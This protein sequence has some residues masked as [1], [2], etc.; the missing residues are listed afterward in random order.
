MITYEIT[1]NLLNPQ[2]TQSGLDVSITGAM[3][4]TISAGNINGVAIP[5]TIINI[6]VDNFNDR[7]ID[8]ML[9]KNNTTGQ[10][11]IW[12]DKRKADKSRSN[13]PVGYEVIEHLIWFQLPKGVNDL[14]NIQINVRRIV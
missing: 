4:I 14:N 13:A 11:D 2:K 7:I 3:Q 8:I 1:G 12:I 10:G 6:P 5:D 9:V